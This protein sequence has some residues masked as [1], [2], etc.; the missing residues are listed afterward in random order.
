VIRPKRKAEL[1]EHALAWVSGQLFGSWNLAGRHMIG[2][3]FMPLLFMRAKGRAALRRRKTVHVYEFIAKAGP[4]SIN[5]CPIFGTCHH[6]NAEEFDYMR[7]RAQS[8][9]EA[10]DAA[11]KKPIT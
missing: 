7:K 6:V 4:R 8:I 1:D 10:Q 2:M 5:G 9:K 3:V 11:M